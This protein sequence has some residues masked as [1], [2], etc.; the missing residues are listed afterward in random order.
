MPILRKT[1]FCVDLFAKL[2]VQSV[3]V[4]SIN[5]MHMFFGRKVY[6]KTRGGHIV[7]MI[8][9]M[10]DLEE[11]LDTLMFLGSLYILHCSSFLCS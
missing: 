10:D 11:Q 6:T 3:V 4:P 8:A 1:R 9:R 5:P 2:P 7:I